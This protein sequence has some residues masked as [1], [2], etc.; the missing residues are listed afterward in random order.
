VK[1]NLFFLILFLAHFQAVVVP[2]FLGIKSINKF[3]NI[4]NYSLI[5]FGFTFLGLASLFEMIDH[6][7]TDWIYISHSSFYNWLF[8]SFLSLGL[9]CLSISVIKKKLTI[10]INLFVS[11]CSIVSYLLIDKKVA[12]LFQIII[13][14]F[15]IINWQKIFKDW[16]LI[17][18]PIFGIVF[19]TLFGTKLL[20][21]NN[22]IWH[23]F[24]GPSGAVSV[25]TFYFVLMRY[26]NKHP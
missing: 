4:K 6:T 22:Q 11:L 25:L 12:L 7:H 23:I 2:L 8:Y 14:I 16:V 21:S 24:I 17:F 19:T 18:Y 5:P 3:K 9:T 15:L 10:G 1:I 13:S 26:E 20:S